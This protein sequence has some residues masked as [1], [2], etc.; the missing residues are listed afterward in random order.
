MCA[1]EHSSLFYHRIACFGPAHVLAENQNRVVL[2]AWHFFFSLSFASCDC[3]AYYFIS[4]C[5]RCAIN[6]ILFLVEL[7][8]YRSSKATSDHIHDDEISYCLIPSMSVFFRSILLSLEFFFLAKFAFVAGI[9]LFSILHKMRFSVILL[10]YLLSV[11]FV[12]TL[13]LPVIVAGDN[14]IWIESK[15]VVLQT[16]AQGQF[17]KE[18]IC[19][20]RNR[21]SAFA[22][23]EKWT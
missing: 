19:R 7:R 10:F 9:S 18:N 14:E 20:K 23:Y 5:L 17:H 1:M 16:F 2:L 6:V 8:L 13:L 12:I 4:R 22:A 21:D 3:I 11:F 15:F